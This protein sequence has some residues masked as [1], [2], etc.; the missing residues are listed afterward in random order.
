MTFAAAVLVLL[1][2]QEKRQDDAKLA[3]PAPVPAAEA[4]ARMGVPEGF[5]VALF[6]GEPA[7]VQPIAFTIDDRGR[8]WVVES[9]SYPH[10]TKPGEPGKDRI[11]I[12]ED[13]DGDGRF[14]SRK[15]FAEKLVNVSG[16]AVGFGG[17]W[18]TGV[19]AFV[20]VPDRN[21]DDVADGPAEVVLDGWD[22]GAK[23]NVSS[24][25]VW[26]P[27]GW[28]YGCNGILS[29]SKVGPPGAPPERRVAFNCGV[30]RYHPVK[31]SFETV[32]H[33]TTNPWG[34]DFDERGELYLT[35]CVIK[36]AF[37]VVP[38]A[39]FERMFGEDKTAPNLYS[40]MPSTCDHFHWKGG[41]WTD[42]R[43]QAAHADS[44]GGH[45]HVGAMIYLGDNWPD[46]YRNSLFTLN[47]HGHRMQNDVLEPR[48]SAMAIRHAKDFLNAN[49]PWFRGLD[50]Q[51]GPD[52]G[53]FVSDWSDTGECH[54][55]DV[56]DAANGRLH[57]ITFGTPAAV[58]ADVARLG[59]ADLVAL[60][61]HKNDWWVRAARRN[62]QERAAAGKL[63]AG[64]PEALRRLLAEDPDPLKRLRAMWALA[65]CGALDTAS[66]LGHADATIRAWAVRLE[67][68]DGDGPI[69]TLAALAKS[70]PSPVVRR[71]LASGLQRL[72][73]AK[74][75]TIA[76]GLVAR[77]EDAE[78]PYLPYL[79]WYGIEPIAA[80]KGEAIKLLAASKMALVR[81]NLTRRMA[82]E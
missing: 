33:G 66:L 3:P 44:G 68:E 73:T 29:N 11:L 28:L 47:L 12:L 72:P 35:N 37:H 31:G 80:T 48:G 60:L 49:D 75:A 74:R 4:A 63:G 15:V 38:G 23:H 79:I 64:T 7:V 42:A 82:S 9:F 27:D 30:W 50:C 18:L 32:A 43:G 36:H 69:E 41:K 8:L 77:G 56:A 59:D 21:G 22:P 40:L 20:F 24:K 10:W 62:L 67:L 39:H 16:I 70:D 17:A 13:S 55:Y 51:Y 14:D 25:P 5:K 58:K 57:K 61:R 19:P 6:A 81:Q 26:G 46:R 45:A 34:L 1:A 52:G 76:A 54:D 65:S 78:D 71:E 2:V 53:V